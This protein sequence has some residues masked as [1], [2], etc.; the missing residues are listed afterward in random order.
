MD[1]NETFLSS[2]EKKKEFP[3]NKS[4]QI[5]EGDRSQQAPASLV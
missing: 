5:G 1:N 2:A 4:G 3:Y